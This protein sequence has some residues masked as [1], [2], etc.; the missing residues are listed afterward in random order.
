MNMMVRAGEWNTGYDE[1]LVVGTDG[2][3][4]NRQK[5]SENEKRMVERALAIHVNR[6][7]RDEFDHD[8]DK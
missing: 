1:Q 6:I 8:G 4:L 5:P 7:Q 2:N 3:I